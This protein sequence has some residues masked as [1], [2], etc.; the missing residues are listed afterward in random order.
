MRKP[1]RRLPS[2]REFLP[3][4]LE[5]IETPVSPAG[6]IMMAAVGLLVVIAVIWA[7]V[8]HIDIVA[9]ASGRVIPA[10]QIKLIQ[11]LQIGVVKRIAVSDGD[12][13]R[14]NDVL[15][16]LDP[17][18]N[19]ADRDRFARDLAQSEL[20]V[21]RLR[22]FLAGNPG[23][24]Q[25]PADVDPVT[26]EMERG[27]LIQQLAAERA[28]LAGLDRQVVEKIAERDQARST[29]EKIDGSL[30]LLNQKLGIYNKLRQQQFSSEITRLDAQ[31]AVFEAGHDRDAA[32]HEVAGAVAAIQALEAQR[33]EAEAEFRR[34]ALD[35]MR[36]AQQAV[37]EQHDELV[38]ATKLTGLQVLRAPV[39][40]T[41]EQ[42]SIHTNGGVVQP[43]QT[44]M[45]I[46]PNGSKLEVEAILANRDAGF[47][48]AGQP[49]EIK[50]EA[51]SY[52]RY[53]LLH[54]TVSSVSRDALRSERDA[55]NPDRDTSPQKASTQNTASGASGDSA[56]L[57]RVTLDEDS[58]RTE[59]G[60]R[61]IEPGMTVT[62]EIKTGDRRII[63]YLL[64]PF[65][66]YQ[67]EALRER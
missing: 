67:H 59:Q 58:I 18:T 44:L 23:A 8:S 41:V 15:V 35:D 6:R 17:T 28:K 19:A 22:A 33:S 66:R 14:A 45:V 21:A 43:A 47:V 39:D 10:G 56:Y 32:V 16:E 49:A 9:T 51:F 64:S 54:G 20:D 27:Q 24:F 7:S 63:S 48:H 62:A 4:A 11:P 38:K 42:L 2:E 61:P 25:P 1:A 31:R 5:I 13:V 40:G 34:Q 52:T 37:S 12:H 57:A 50:V 30:P 36:K 55:P 29:I 53:G 65:M 26:A 46:V 3:A 60:L